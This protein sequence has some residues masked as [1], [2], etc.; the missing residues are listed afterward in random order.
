[1]DRAELAK[2]FRSLRWAGQVQ[3][4]IAR[5]YPESAS[6]IA[7]TAEPACHGSSAP[8]SLIWPAGGGVKLE[9][10]SS[11]TFFLRL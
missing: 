8:G 10:V 11:A 3:G 1:M 9:T 7:G 5:S 2:K 4:V 6:L